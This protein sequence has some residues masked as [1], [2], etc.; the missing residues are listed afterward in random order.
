MGENILENLD[1]I[2]LLN[3][4]M[5]AMVISWQYIFFLEWSFKIGFASVLQSQMT[6]AYKSVILRFAI[7]RFFDNPFIS[8][9]IQWY[10]WKALST[11]FK[12]DRTKYKNPTGQKLPNHVI[13]YRPY[14]E[15][16][17]TNKG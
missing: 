2:G 6:K 5:I 16:S 14:Q 17:F 3:S 4:K 9:R 11:W 1:F 10:I 7:A 12:I 15:S 8:R 13:A